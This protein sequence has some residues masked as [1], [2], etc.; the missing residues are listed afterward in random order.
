MFLKA[1]FVLQGTVQGNGEKVLKVDGD[2][3]VL[4]GVASAECISETLD[5]DA[6]HN[7]L[8]DGDLFVFFQVAFGHQELDE[9]R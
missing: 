9:I 4:L 8:V 5:L 2:C 3:A 7:E 1:S 6:K